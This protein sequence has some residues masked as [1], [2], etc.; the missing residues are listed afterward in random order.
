[1]VI[2]GS[3]QI[4][5][6]TG[7]ISVTINSIKHDSI[8][9]EESIDFTKGQVADGSIVY[10]VGDEIKKRWDFANDVPLTETQESDL[11][12]LYKRKETMNL[13][14][15]WLDCGSTYIVFM[16]NMSR[17]LGTPKGSLRYR[18]AFQEV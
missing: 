8:A 11:A 7:I 3:S 10:D 14:E 16:E 5:I 13:T 12:T 1:M 17:V 18:F 9:P 15:N 2:S 4:I 6:G